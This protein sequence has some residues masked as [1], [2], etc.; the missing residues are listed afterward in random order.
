MPRWPRRT[1][2]LGL[3]ALVV[4]AGAGTAYATVSAPGPRYRLATVIPAQV[5]A[6]IDVVGTLSP[7]QQADVSFPVSGTVAAVAARSGQRVT[8]G[9]RLGSLSKASLRAALAAAQSTLDQANLQVSHDIAGQ[10]QAAAGSGGPGSGS[11]GSGSGPGS[12][13]GSASAALR[14][15]Q[16]AVLR[17]QRRADHALARARAALAQ[18]GQ[19]CTNPAPSPSGTPSASRTPVPGAT[20]SAGATPLRPGTPAAAGTPSPAPSGRP[21][22]APTPTSAPGNCAHATKQVLAA[23][24]VVLHAQQALSRQL[25]ALGAALAKAIRGTGASG[26]G[27]GSGAGNGGGSS[28]PASAAQ[29][30]ADQA[31]ADADAAQL[32]VAQQNLDNAIVRSPIS[33]TVVSVA[34]SPGTAVTAGSTAFEIA[35]LD[36][37]QVQTEVPV[38]DLPA[39]KVGQRASV[40]ADGLASPL[41]GSVISIGLIPDTSNSPVTYPVTIGLAGPPGGLHPDGFASVTIS[42]GHSRGV[43]VPTSA[44]HYGKHGATVTVYAAGRARTVK[45]TVGTKGP[46]RTRI[47]AGLRAGQRVVLAVLSKPLPSGNQNQG[48]GFGPGGGAVVLGP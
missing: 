35:G 20:P 11:G 33:G 40:R 45:V 15:L 30:A 3:A 47:M 37:Y 24:T 19:V 26:G 22:P 21:S 12:A 23:E 36:S 42:T 34:V 13:G 7:A 10:D 48:P 32:T 1:T 18:A 27:S 46:L 5:S 9:Q 16:Q 43:S 17:A 39:L 6:A 4:L 31:T 2:M 29:L 14:P 44:V 8:A 25:S 38:T 41:T 28:G